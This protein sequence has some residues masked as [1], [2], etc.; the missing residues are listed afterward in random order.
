MDMD[1]SS[2]ISAELERAEAARISGNEGRARVCARR[3]A[4]MAARE[5]L[6]RR[7]GWAFDQS[8]GKTN[9]DSVFEVL[10]TLATFPGLA[11]HLKQAAIHLTMRVN[12]EL[13]LPLGIDL[14]DEAH[15]L[16]GGLV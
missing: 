9:S 15:K 1:F 13:Q 8:K 2:E 6:S 10:Q 5:F 12:E 14:I 11:P 16:I 4:G 7:E 3:A